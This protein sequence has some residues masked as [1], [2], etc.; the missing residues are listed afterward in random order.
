MHQRGF[1]TSKV[2]GPLAN[3]LSSGYTAG[4]AG[5]NAGLRIRGE[6]GLRDDFLEVCSAPDKPAAQIISEFMRAYV[7]GQAVTD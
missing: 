6:R 7:A 2:R 1:S 4:M 5:K 3:C